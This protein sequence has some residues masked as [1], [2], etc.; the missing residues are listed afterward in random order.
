MANRQ[1]L[2]Q[3]N[4][5]HVDLQASFVWAIN[6]LFKAVDFPPRIDNRIHDLTSLVIKFGFL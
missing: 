4:Y 1:H 6:L 3:E 5:Y 2:K